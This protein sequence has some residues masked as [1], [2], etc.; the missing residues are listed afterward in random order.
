MIL[1]MV[2]LV[3]EQ[4]SVIVRTVI[5]TTVN[6]MRDRVLEQNILVL[7]DKVCTQVDEAINDLRTDS[8][9][10][11]IAVSCHCC[12]FHPHLVPWVPTISIVSA[13]ISAALHLTRVE[14]LG[15]SSPMLWWIEDRLLSLIIIDLIDLDHIVYIDIETG[16]SRLLWRLL[17]TLALHP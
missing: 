12:G 5:S 16:T 15:T 10:L 9:P 7:G 1:K 8:L 4:V 13:F 6:D 14:L 17:T 2:L 11:V 3:G